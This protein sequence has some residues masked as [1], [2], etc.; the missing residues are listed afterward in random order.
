MSIET[1]I[2]RF[3]KKTGVRKSRWTVPLNGWCHQIDKRVKLVPFERS[4]EVCAAGVQFKLFL[5][6]HVL[7]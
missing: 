2:N 7:L 3:V 1:R 5:T 4:E 6:F